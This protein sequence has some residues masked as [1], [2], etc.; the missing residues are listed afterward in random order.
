[1]R[2]LC[3]HIEDIYIVGSPSELTSIISKM[4]YSMQNISEATEQLA[5]QLL[6]YSASNKG[7]QYKKVVSKLLS[8]RINLYQASVDVNEMQNEIVAYQNKIFRYEEVSES[9][10]Q[11]NPHLVNRININVEVNEVQFNLSKMITVAAELKNYSDIIYH[12][13]KNLIQAKEQ[14]ALIWRDSQYDI[15]AQFIDDVCREIIDALKLFDDYRDA[16]E[17]RIKELN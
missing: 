5:H 13:T 8:L 9:A 7:A 10:S 15:F 6:K 17:E 2:K 4:D 11:P 12:H 1:M 3:E 16:L 14:A